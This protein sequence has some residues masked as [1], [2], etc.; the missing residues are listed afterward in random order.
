MNLPVKFIPGNGCREKRPGR[1]EENKMIHIRSYAI[2]ICLAMFLI[3]F[4]NAQDLSGYRDYRLSM[5]LAAV[6]E[7]ANLQVSDAKSICL[8]PALIQELGWQSRSVFNASLQ[9]DPV[10]GITFDFYNGEL[11]RILV[12]Y[13]PDR[14]EGLTDEDLIESISVRHGAPTKPDENISIYSSSHLYI[15]G[16]KVIA[17]WE[18]SQYSVSLFRLSYQSTPGMLILSKRLETL[19]QAAMTKSSLLDILE[20]PQREVDRRRQQDEENRAAGL[21]VRPVNK[22]NFRP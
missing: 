15:Q 7:L 1:S 13:N 19:A 14:T 10:K 4:G 21:K 20:A 6:A 2:S 16:G 17:R 5:N 3:P 9:T 11:F 12:S 18:D 8:R 22:A